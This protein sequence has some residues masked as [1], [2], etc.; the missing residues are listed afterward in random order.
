MRIVS[1]MASQYLALSLF[2]MLL[3][4][5]II[6]N[7]KST[8]DSEKS[9]AVANSLS[10][11]FSQEYL[12]ED[13]APSM[14]SDQFKASR[15]GSTIT[16]LS[17]LFSSEISGV[18]IKT[19]RLGTIMHLNLKVDEFE[20]ILKNSLGGADSAQISAGN[21]DFLATLVSLLDSQDSIPY[22]MDIVLALEQSPSKLQNEDPDEIATR[23]GQVSLYAKRL[24]EAGLPP[25]LV[26]SGIGPG[27]AGRINLYFHRYKVFNPLGKSD[28][29]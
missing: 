23:V 26:T 11:V 18:D 25:K 10:M 8:F 16:Q 22:R 24:E 9:R 20:K 5:F 17:A 13:L 19:N 2:I 3:S 27:K 7:S 12:P 21:F 1:A 29:K 28:L 4:F 15:S 14:K 6:L